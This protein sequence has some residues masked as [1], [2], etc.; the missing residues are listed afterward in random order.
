[1]K[2]KKKPANRNSHCYLLAFLSMN[3]IALKLIQIMLCVESPR[4]LVCQLVTFLVLPPPPSFPIIIH[5]RIRTNRNS[6]PPSHHPQL[7]CVNNSIV[8]AVMYRHCKRGAWSFEPRIRTSSSPSVDDL[9]L[10]FQA[11]VKQYPPPLLYI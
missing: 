9:L 2:G 5:E 3:Q 6:L 10:L 1:M 8:I 11:R 4:S 7:F